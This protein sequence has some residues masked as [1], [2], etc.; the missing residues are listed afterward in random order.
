[1]TTG[2]LKL[3]EDANKRNLFFMQLKEEETRRRMNRNSF[4]PP[5]ASDWPAIFGAGKLILYILD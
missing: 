1:M 4:T 5:G 3:P 2:D